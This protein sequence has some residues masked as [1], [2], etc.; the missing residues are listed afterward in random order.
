LGFPLL[1][2]ERILMQEGEGTVEHIFFDC[3][4]D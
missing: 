3:G 1:I 4:G 2:H